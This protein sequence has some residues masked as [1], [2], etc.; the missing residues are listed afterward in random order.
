MELRALFSAV[1]LLVQ[2]QE[3]MSGKKE[4][5]CLRLQYGFKGSL[6]TN[7]DMRFITHQNSAATCLTVRDAPNA[8]RC[9]AGGMWAYAV[10]LN[11]TSTR[12]EIRDILGR[13]R[14]EA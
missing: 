2:R 12:E 5:K 4:R 13:R 8:Q 3:S 9:V 1:S 6:L 7:Q 11:P 10:W 14:N